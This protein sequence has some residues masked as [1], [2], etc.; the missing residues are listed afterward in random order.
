MSPQ[1]NIAITSN[2]PMD[3]S[4]SSERRPAPRRGD[5]LASGRSARADIHEISVI[6]DEPHII[7]ARYPEAIERV[8]KLARRL[9][10][11]GWYTADHTHYARI[12]VCR[13][14]MTST[15]RVMRIS[16]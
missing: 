13:P 9:R 6:P 14:R 11:D 2:R 16:E 4:A 10:V 8:R 5:V 15:S 1:T 7:V 12:A 3:A